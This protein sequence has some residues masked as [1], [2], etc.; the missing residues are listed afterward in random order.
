MAYSCFFLVQGTDRQMPSVPLRPRSPFF[1]V[2]PEH[3]PYAKSAVRSVSPEKF[4]RPKRK[5]T[6]C[7]EDNQSN[8]KIDN[9]SYQ[10]SPEYNNETRKKG[11][12]TKDAEHTETS[13]RENNQR[14]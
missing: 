7:D 14:T 12:N 6:I 1:C 8:A 10:N 4:K 2:C 5:E 11:N 9:Y 3:N 13:V